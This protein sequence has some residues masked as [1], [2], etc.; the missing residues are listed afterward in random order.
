MAVKRT[1]HE[2]CPKCGERNA[3]LDG[4]RVSWPLCKCAKAGPIQS[5]PRAVPLDSVIF[6]PD[7]NPER[8]ASD[9]MER[10][11]NE[12]VRD[13]TELA[14]SMAAFVRKWVPYE[15]S[16]DDSKLTPAQLER[17]EEATAEFDRTLQ[18]LQGN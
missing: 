6:V 11:I 14:K 9:D 2:T 7:P 17:L 1:I 10:L 12:C 13:M 8:Y 3:R 18:S 15:S 16:L 4:N 5:P